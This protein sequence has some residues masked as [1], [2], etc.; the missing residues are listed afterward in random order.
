MS[1]TQTSSPRPR[2]GSCWL[3]FGQRLGLDLHAAELA[4]LRAIT[5]RYVLAGEFRSDLSCA[6]PTKV[7]DVAAPP[8]T[9]DEQRRTETGATSSH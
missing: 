4:K 9:R 7:A 6:P 2:P 8:T 1:E 3:S 5:V